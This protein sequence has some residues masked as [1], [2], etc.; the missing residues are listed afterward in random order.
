M[1]QAKSLVA[2]HNL[3]TSS[4]AWENVGDLNSLLAITHK[5]SQPLI[6]KTRN[7]KLKKLSNY[8]GMVNMIKCLLK[9]DE[10]DS[11]AFSLV[12]S[13]VPRV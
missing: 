1:E 7:T 12:Q 13:L 2:C 6:Y 9:V 8:S 5:Q 10:K 3:D 11:N 4:P